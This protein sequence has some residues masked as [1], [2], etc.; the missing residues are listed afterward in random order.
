MN[1]LIIISF[2]FVSLQGL[3]QGEELKIDWEADKKLT[4]A[5]FQ[6]KP[7]PNISYHANTNSGIAFSWSLRTSGDAAEFIYSVSNSFYPLKSWVKGKKG[8]RELLAHEQLHFD[9]SEL[10]ARKLRQQLATYELGE[11]VKQDLNGIYQKNEEGRRQMQELYD[12]ETDHG[13]KKEAQA[14]WQ[15]FIEGELL[16]L[17]EFS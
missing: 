2:L 13:L 12:Q 8:S 11:D 4:W 10:Y 16:K 15:A 17:A 3:A 6:G 5:D 1:Y 9:I 14:R 7:D